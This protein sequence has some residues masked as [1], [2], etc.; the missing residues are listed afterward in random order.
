MVNIGKVDKIVWQRF[1]GIDKWPIS[2]MHILLPSML[3]L[4]G[5]DIE[6]ILKTRME[7]SSD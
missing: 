7:C 6:S 4:H 1:N 3:R 2:R 5:G